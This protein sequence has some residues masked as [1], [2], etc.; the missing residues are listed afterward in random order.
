MRISAL[1]SLVFVLAAAGQGVAQS[2]NARP[3]IG[4]TLSGG[5]AKGLAHIGVLQAIDSAGLNIEFITGTS[6]GSVVGGLYAAG[7]SGKEI[8]RMARPL[9]WEVLFSSSP[10]LS[11]ISIEEKSEY[12]KYALIV[13]VEKKKLKIGRGLIDGQELWLKLAEFFEPVYNIRDFSKLPIPFKCMGTD[14][15]TGNVVEMDHGNIVNA[16]RASMAIPSVFTP[17]NYEDKL[18]ADGGMVDNFPVMNV[19]Q[20]GADFVIGVNLN[21]GLSKAEDLESTLDI[22][23]QIAF[24]KDAATIEKNKAACD[25]YIFPD[26]TGYGAG[27]FSSS[28]S[29]M[30]IGIRTGHLYYPYFKKLADSLNAI[31]GKV[32]YK[33]DRLPKNK[34][35]TIS[36]YSAEGFK[37]TKEKFFFGMLNLKD[38]QNYS[39]PDINT[40]IHRVYGSRYY[41]IVR[42]DFL[43]D[44]NGS[45]E[46]RFNVEEN[47]LT[48]IKVALNY[49]SFTQIGLFLNLTSRDLLFKESRALVSVSISEFP[50]LYA[51]Y[52]KYINKKRTARVVLDFYYQSINFPLYK[53]FRLSQTLNS[54]YRVLDAQ[55]QKNINLYSY[56]GIGQQYNNSKIKTEES[57]SLIYN[58][59][60]NYWFSYLTYGL[61]NT[62]R[63]YYPTKGW[64]VRAKAGYVFN[65][66]PEHEYTY[67]DISGTSDSVPINSKDYVKL[68]MS[69]T[70]YSKLNSKFTLIQNG[71]LGY[72]IENNTFVA[73]K[74]VLGGINDII[75]NQL[76]FAGLDVSEIKTGSMASLQFGLQYQLSKK[77][78]IIARA[79]AALYNFHGT[80]PENIS[81][82]SNLLSGYGLTYG[83]SSPIGPIEVTVMYSD[84]DAKVRNYINLGFTF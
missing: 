80:R 9:D 28:D 10:Q 76:P 47:P 43:P 73:D 71:S 45:T 53:D 41:K 6:M 31:Y 8:E 63:K 38:N 16:I 29:I 12:E 78:F 15:S 26:L 20:M 60:N 56:F 39:Y 49:N 68:M 81:A 22:L 44:T 32:E 54:T 13:P 30:D 82:K 35:I 3:K 36:K 23:G 46:M 7:Y 40:A 34:H 69:A 11:E 64:N 77:S 83:L 18:L 74:F 50:Q 14:L 52:F 2:K 72:I 5:G 59:Q 4:I 55:I 33:K 61:N 66:D 37:H 65:Q 70:H 75:L 58:G 21:H 19:K 84:Q 67:D 42:Y 48:A 57:P 17:V 79:N 51:E 62:N 1:L 25:I 24:F 27:S